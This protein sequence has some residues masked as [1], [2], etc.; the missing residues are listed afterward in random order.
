MEPTIPVVF[1]HAYPLHAGMWG[2]E[3]ARL[4]NRTLLTPNF[5]GFGG[6]PPGPDTLDG[7]A[8][9][10]VADLDAAAIERAIVVGLSMGGYVAFRICARWPE[11]VAGLVLADTR[12][13]A[14]SEAAAAK[15]TQ[16]A[17]RVRREGVGWLPHALLPDLVG[18]KTRQDRPELVR[19]VGNMILQA[20]PEGVAR[21][22]LAMRDRPDSSELLPSIEVP[23]L[24]LAGEQDAL[25]PP[26][27]A[28]LIAERTRRGLLAVIPEAAHLSN[29][30]NPK[31]FAAALDAFLG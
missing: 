8:E 24:A 28:R 20:N 23:V 26:A 18:E 16:Q 6:R 15:R 19:E 25:T 22:L 27:E 4:A 1:L 14:D 29:L 11:R 7:F 9:A 31:A 17:E 10:I 30:E 12:A 5:P 3:V 2:G 13:G 21:A